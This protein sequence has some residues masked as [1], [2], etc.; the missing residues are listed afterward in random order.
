MPSTKLVSAGFRSIW[1]ISIFVAASFSGAAQAQLAF[2]TLSPDF[3]PAGVEVRLSGTGFPT[4]GPLTL[5]VGGAEATVVERTAALLRFN[6]PAAA[7]TGPVIV[8]TGG[9][10][11][12]F[13]APFTV[14][15]FISA[16]IAPQLQIPAANYT[17]G[18]FYSDAPGT[19]P[20]YAVEVARGEPTIV[21]A[22]AGDTDPVVMAVVTDASASV[23]LNAQSTA[24]ALVFAMPGVQTLHHAEAIA[25]LNF[26]SAR[27]ETA[28]LASTIQSLVAAG[29]DYLANPG[30]EASMIT[31]VEAFLNG[32]QPAPPTFS[33]G[34]EAQMRRDDFVNGTQPLAAG[35]PRDLDSPGFGGLRRL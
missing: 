19:G 18:T 5:S 33:A 12:R 20:G 21:V 31:L 26:F 15:R 22:S 29:Q 35:Y 10:E 32:Y 27:P 30:V 2:T 3:G 1:I 7:T 25:R 8:T 9:T 6:V 17:V 34:H 16:Q 28:N 23:V 4:T 14:T 24:L 11:H 13:P